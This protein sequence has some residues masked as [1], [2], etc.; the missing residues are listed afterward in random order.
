MRHLALPGPHEH[1]GGADGRRLGC[2]NRGG[3]RDPSV[4]RV[5]EVARGARVMTPTKPSWALSKRGWDA[6]G[7]MR[8]RIARR[9]AAEQVVID[10]GRAG[11]GEARLAAQA[12]R[13]LG[14]LLRRMDT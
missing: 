8:L 1:G 10:A 6:T 14:Q 3:I 2:D 4:D 11:Y 13:Q 9:M 12:R 7:R 5:R